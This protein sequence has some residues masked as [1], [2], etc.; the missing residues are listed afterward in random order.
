MIT[1]SSPPTA[2]LIII[3]N[4]IWFISNLSALERLVYVCLW[5]IG[6]HPI[7]ALL[8]AAAELL[9]STLFCLSSKPIAQD[10]SQMSIIFLF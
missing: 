5:R 4:R 10:K 6:V 1:M 8:K 2:D 9:H 3:P 7:E